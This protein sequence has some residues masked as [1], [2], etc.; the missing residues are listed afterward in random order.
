M[1]EIGIRALISCLMAGLALGF[2]GAAQAKDHDNLEENLPVELDDA[3][4]ASY[5]AIEVHLPSRWDKTD[6][7]KERVFLAPRFEFGIIPNAEL[8]LEVPILMGEAER[9]GSGDIVTEFLY[10]LY[11]ED[12]VL[13]ASSLVAGVRAPSGDKSEVTETTLGFY[14]TKAVV[15]TSLYHY[16]HANVLWKRLFDEDEETQREDRLK[17]IAGYSQRVGSETLFVADYIYEQDREED[18]E[19]NIAEAGFRYHLSPRWVLAAGAGAGLDS[20]SPDYRLSAGAQF[21]Y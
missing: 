5:R 9:E 10:N 18:K 1:K 20:E 3:Y 19:L 2:P 21:T 8:S 11:T 7:G 17:L 14:F 6:E 12:L 4:P 15:P 13:P 16:V